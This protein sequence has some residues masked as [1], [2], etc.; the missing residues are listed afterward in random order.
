MTAQSHVGDELPPKDHNTLTD[1]SQLKKA[2]IRIEKHLNKLVSMRG[3][4]MAACKGVREQIAEEYRRA[5][6]KG[7]V[8]RA[9]RAVIEQRQLQRK[10]NNVSSKLDEDLSSEYEA[11]LD[12][13][14]QWE[15]PL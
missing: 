3:E 9:L 11:Y 5:K 7:I 1:M 6:E 12:A 10:L 13:V 4:H 15:L 8:K 14:K 2:I